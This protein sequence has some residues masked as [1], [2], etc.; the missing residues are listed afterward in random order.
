MKAVRQHRFGG[1]EVLEVEDVPDLSAAP[2]TVRV[3]VAAAGVHVLDTSIRA[4][5]RVH[6]RLIS[7]E[8]PGNGT[9][10]SPCSS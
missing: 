8:T 5:V 1:P 6:R 2:G 7:R 4:G 3:A 9:G 10:E